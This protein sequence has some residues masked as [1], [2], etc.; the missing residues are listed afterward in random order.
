MDR[1]YENY[2]YFFDNSNNFWISLVFPGL[3]HLTKNKNL[4]NRQTRIKGA[5]FLLANLI[6][7]VGFTIIETTFLEMGNPINLLLGNYYYISAI[8]IFIPFDGVTLILPIITTFII[9]FVL[10]MLSFLDAYYSV[11]IE[12]H[13]RKEAISLL[14]TKDIQF[15]KRA[16]EIHYTPDRIEK[17]NYRYLG[18]NRWSYTQTRIKTNLS[19][20]A[21]TRA[22]FLQRIIDHAARKM[23]TSKTDASSIKDIYK[24]AADDNVIDIEKIL[25]DI[26][27]TKL[28]KENPKPKKAPEPAEEVKLPKTDS[29]EAKMS[30][31][32]VDA[33]SDEKELL[34]IINT[35]DDLNVKK[36]ALSG[37]SDEEILFDLASDCDEKDI[38]RQAFHMIVSEDLKLESAKKNRDEYIRMR[39]LTH[40]TL[41]ESLEDISQNAQYSDVRNAATSM[42]EVEKK[43]P[44]S[45]SCDEFARAFKMA[46]F[47]DNTSRA[48]DEILP[49]WKKRCNA[50]GN[51]GYAMTASIYFENGDD[52]KA[53]M[54]RMEDCF[55]EAAKKRHGD[56]LL[57]IW[58]LELALKYIKRYERE[59]L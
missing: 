38:R 51:L 23:A 45:L 33:I 21:K 25:E 41:P 47:R 30:V 44:S 17:S 31:D 5:I 2:R 1:E 37:I 56:E 32:D 11:G 18:P 8:N 50:D 52:P 43:D 58:Y 28:G 48:F 7:I 53:T 27:Q 49:L 20:E 3:Y 54:K 12:N 24:L 14:T 35:Q 42:L 39:A 9:T 59:N 46:I 36:R 6:S 15:L 4:F 13:Y 57:G 10:S 29:G 19:R 26:I 16:T 40:I 22:E 34:E 55:N